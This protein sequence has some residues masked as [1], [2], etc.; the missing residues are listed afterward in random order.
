MSCR[1]HRKR[2][3]SVWKTDTSKAFPWYHFRSAL[4][5]SHC[6]TSHVTVHVSE[7]V[8][9]HLSHVFQSHTERSVPTRLKKRCPEVGCP[10]PT[11]SPFQWLEIPL[12]T[13]RPDMIPQHCRRGR[14]LGTVLIRQAL[15]S[16][17]ILKG[18]QPIVVN[19]MRPHSIP[20]A[21]GMCY[22]FLNWRSI[23][24]ADQCLRFV[25]VSHSVFLDCTP[26]CALFSPV[27]V[28]SIFWSL[29]SIACSHCS[30]GLF[31][32]YAFTHS[33]F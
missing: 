10:F 22:L 5:L 8:C 19:C 2:P 33:S 1:F 26:F 4:L 20:S 25:L 29:N 11:G 28:V 30:Y 21:D 27:G 31:L 14:E 13:K 16:G 32:L 12:C 18:M 9:V 24:T 23:L 7:K 3:A 6:H 17:K 15:L